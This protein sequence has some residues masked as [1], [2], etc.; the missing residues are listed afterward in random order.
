MRV[1]ETV[2]MEQ[3]LQRHRGRG[4][5]CYLQGTE[6]RCRDWNWVNSGQSSP[7]CK[8]RV[9]QRP[10]VL[11]LR[12]TGVNSEFHPKRNQGPLEVLAQGWCDLIHTV[13]VFHYV[14]CDAWNGRSM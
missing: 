5:A 11:S 1:W 14:S 7:W 6:G 10:A 2:E 3:K 4:P 12:G 13:V 9:P 8:A